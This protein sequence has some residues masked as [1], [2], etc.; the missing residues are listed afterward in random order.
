MKVFPVLKELFFEALFPRVCPVCE[1]ILPLPRGWAKELS[2]KTCSNSLSPDLLKYYSS[3]LLCEKC[4]AEITFVSSPS[5]CICSRPL[6]EEEGPY[7]R[8]CRKEAFL[9]DRG[10]ALMVHDA[11][12]KK[13]IY[14]LKFRNKKDN[15]LWLGFALALRFAPLLTEWNSRVLV[16][17]PLHRKRLRQ[18][19]FNQT[20]LIAECLSF[21]LEKLYGISL[22]IDSE[23]LFRTENTLPQRTLSSAERGRNVRSAFSA[24]REKS[25][26]RVVLVDDIFTS[27][28]TL[29]ACAKVLKE[30][31]TEQVCFLTASIVP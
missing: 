6:D 4:L 13:I 18:R 19:G 26:R 16:P 12:A 8:H 30:Q 14:D 15:A 11:P 21:W 1:T 10:A 29:N 20:E 25:Y 3:M 7:C 22:P 31:G 9:F 28:S 27:G 5:C 24:A 23:F 17:V 2:D